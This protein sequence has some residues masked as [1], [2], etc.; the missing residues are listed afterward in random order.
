MTNKNSSE[1]PLDT[2]TK[3]HR[4]TPEQ[5]SNE[6]VATSPN[7]PISMRTSNESI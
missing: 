6:K 7:S 5:Q 3:L 4:E 1:H 2:S